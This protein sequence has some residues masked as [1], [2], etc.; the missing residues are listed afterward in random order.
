MVQEWGG[1]AKPRVSPHSSNSSLFHNLQ[2][3]VR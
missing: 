1:G 3:P 2:D